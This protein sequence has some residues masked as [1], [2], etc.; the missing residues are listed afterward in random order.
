MNLNMCMCTCTVLHYI[1]IVHVCVATC[2]I[3]YMY[4]SQFMYSQYSC[5]HDTTEC[6]KHYTCMSTRVHVPCICTHVCARTSH[7]AAERVFFFFF[8][9]VLF[10]LLFFV[11]FVLFFGTF[12]IKDSKSSAARPAGISRLVCSPGL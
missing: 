9:F 6:A 11:F 12:S 4:I 2:Y 8:F 7:Q 10:F 3:P 5:T 1:H